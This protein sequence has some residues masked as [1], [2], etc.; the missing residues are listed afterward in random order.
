[1]DNTIE[2]GPFV[3]TYRVDGIVKTKL[4]DEWD[5]DEKKKVQLDWKAKNI[6]SA[7]LEQDQIRQI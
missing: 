2:N 6:I 4:R 1:M 3:P 7:A 5:N